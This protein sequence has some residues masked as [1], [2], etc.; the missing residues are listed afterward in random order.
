[1]WERVNKKR[2]E[3]EKIEK[4]NQRKKKGR[5]RESNTFYFRKKAN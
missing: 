5:R 2:G 3:I 4:I 1:M